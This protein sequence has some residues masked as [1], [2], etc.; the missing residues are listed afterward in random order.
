MYVVYEGALS[1]LLVFSLLKAKPAKHKAY[2][3]MLNTKESRYMLLTI[4]EV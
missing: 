4:L 1:Q 2:M 3:V